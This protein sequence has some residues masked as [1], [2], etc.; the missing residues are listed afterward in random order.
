MHLFRFVLTSKSYGR[1]LIFF[2][3]QLKS[4]GEHQVPGHT[5]LSARQL[6]KDTRRML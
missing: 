6:G 4:W 2:T 5:E 3:G 1:N